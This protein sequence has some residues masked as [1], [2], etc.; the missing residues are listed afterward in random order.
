MDASGE[1]KKSGDDMAVDE[2]ERGAA[3]EEGK[4]GGDLDGTIWVPKTLAHLSKGAFNRRC[5]A[6]A[7]T[8]DK[9]GGLLLSRK[10]AKLLFDVEIAPHAFLF[11]VDA[12][13]VGASQPE[14][15]DVMLEV[16]KNFDQPS[17]YIDTHNFKLHALVKGTRYVLEWVHLG[18]KK[19]RV[20][21]C[22]LD[23]D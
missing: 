17:S 18:P 4:G 21:F 20:I 12:V 23:E 15:T 9:E 14:L 6:V 16:I 10:I 5:I 2:C 1:G 22:L 3:E 7:L 13:H 11:R 19:A 8:R